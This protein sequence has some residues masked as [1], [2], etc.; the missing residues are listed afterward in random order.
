MEIVGG[1]IVGFAMLGQF[2]EPMVWL[3]IA[4]IVTSGV[5]LAWGGR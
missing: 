4:V 2:P 5:V 1:V 3:G